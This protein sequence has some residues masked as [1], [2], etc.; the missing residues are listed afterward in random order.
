MCTLGVSLA[1]RWCPA[2]SVFG[3]SIPSSTKKPV[4]VGLPLTPFSGPAHSKEPYNLYH[5]VLLYQNNLKPIKNMPTHD[6][7]CADPEHSVR[8][9]LF[10]GVSYGSYSRKGSVPVFLMKPIA[11]C[12]VPGGGGGTN[13]PVSHPLDPPMT[14]GGRGTTD[15]QRHRSS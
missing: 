10:H 13:P 5:C 4:K 6:T 1:G 11:I 2:C 14:Q 3:S 7:T 8:G 12:D 15:K 9:I